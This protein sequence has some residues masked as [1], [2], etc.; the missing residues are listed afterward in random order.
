[1]FVIFHSLKEPS[2]EACIYRQ[3]G[4]EE[5][6]EWVEDWPEPS[7]GPN[8]LIIKVAA[9]SI[10]PKDALLRKGKFSKTLAREPLPRITGMDL[11][12]TVVQVGENVTRF[13]IGDSVYGMTNH[14]SG[15]VLS[16]YTELK[17]TE[18][19]YAPVAI[20]L[21]EA[22]SIPLAGQT[23]LQ[24]LR[25]VAKISSGKKV[26][27]TGASG[28]VGHFAIQLAKHFS[29][30]VHGLCSTRN[31]DFVSSLGADSVHDY[32]VNHPSKI[33]QQYDVIFDA[34]GRFKAGDFAKQLRKDG[35]FITTLPS[36]QS[37]IYEFL[38]RMKL[39]KKSRLV[40]VRSIS[41]DLSY[42]ASLVDSGELCPHIEKVYEKAQ[43]IAAHSHI[44]SGHSRGKVVVSI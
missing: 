20:P 13:N 31:I 21:V 8:S 19:A 7:C 35:I 22:S 43:V 16:R 6:L 42:L 37:L 23:A 34:A 26:L 10:N 9:S 40:V 11:S 39:N 12:G 1:M 38:A 28:G 27:I 30:E 29:A 5:V 2:L 25:D 17:E 33:D 14:F 36:N 32:T 41:S 4:K 3:F 24:A 44:Q 18:A 15:G